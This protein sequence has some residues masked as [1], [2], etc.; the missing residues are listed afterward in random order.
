MWYSGSELA[1]SFLLQR[2]L[3][4]WLHR[5]GATSF[6]GAEHHLEQRVPKFIGSDQRQ[7]LPNEDVDERSHRHVNVSMLSDRYVQKISEP[8]SSSWVV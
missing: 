6:F 3:R 2:E 7:V 5:P 8:S 1:F 4:V